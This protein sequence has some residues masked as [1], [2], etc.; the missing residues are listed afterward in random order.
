MYRG[1]QARDGHPA[2]ATLGVEAARHLKPA[3]QVE[4]SGGVNGTP[5]V[6]G[7]VVVAASGGGVV[8]AYRVSSG[9]RIWQVDGLGA[10]SSSPTIEGGRVIV[11]SLNGHIY[12]LDLRGGGRLWDAM[13][14]GGK[15]AIWSSPTVY[16]QLVVVG[17]GSQYG[18]KPLEEGGVVAFDLATGS[19]VWEL[20]A[21]V[22]ARAD[23]LAGDGIWST[24]A[25]DSA[26]HGYIG[27][28]NPD[29][30]VLAFDVATGHRLWMTSFHPD[31]G[32]DVDVGA[33]PIVLQ[34]GGRE[35]VAV[36]SDA[37][38]F[39]VLDAATGSVVWSR[40]LVNG[41]AVHGLLASPAYDGKYFYVPSAGEPS[42]MFA[43]DVAG[44]KTQWTSH[45]GLP[46]Y[47]APAIGNGVLVFG[48]GDVFGDPN[49]GGMVAMSSRDGTV[50]W[51]RDLHSAVFSGPAISGSM[52]LV[53]DSRGDLIAFRPACAG[54]L[55]R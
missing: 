14:P 28:G 4:L 23:C 1:D 51:T 41:S 26:G 11:G 46:V 19:Q 35:E 22:L 7:G 32:R 38:V 53:G 48:T 47:S 16:G 29:D 55:N 5:A 17:V 6:A 37:G 15:P 25:I 31:E 54:R 18:D 42:G 34:A 8:A 49:A 3:W 40:D 2:G 44:G 20:C 45:A 52:V 33:T 10:I 12:A 24:P 13:V 36:G 50:L 27:V 39:K 30:G 21:R 9:T 43:L